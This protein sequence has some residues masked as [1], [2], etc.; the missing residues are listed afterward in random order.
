MACAM[1]LLPVISTFSAAVAEQ[2][3]LSAGSRNQA[4]RSSYA[5]ATHPSDSYFSLNRVLEID[6]EM[7]PADWEQ[8]RRQT[9]TLFDILSG[10]CLASPQA[11]VFSWFRASVSVD[12][13]TYGE[14]GVRKK[15]FLGSL[16][17][18][19]PALKL[20]FDKFIDDQLLGGVMQRLTLNN[21]KQDASMIN[22]CLASGV[23]AAAGLPTPRCNFATVSVNGEKLGL[24]VHVESVKNAFLAGHFADPG[25]N[26]YEGTVSDFR[27][28][29]RGTFVKK[30][31]RTAAEW[32]D[33][34]AVVEALQDPSAAGLEKLEAAVDLESFLTFWATEVLVG[35]WD[36]YAGN[37]NNFYLYREPGAPF[38]FIPWGLDQVFSSIDGPFD[39]FRSPPSVTAHG[40]IAHRLY[41][42]AA[43]RQ[44]Y[45]ARLVE[46]LDT[47]WN[48]EQLLRQ[49]DEMADLVQIHALAARRGKARSDT[50]RV[51]RFI[52]QRRA[53]ILAAIDPLPPSWPWP[54]T[55]ADICWPQV[56][57]FD[58]A[59]ATTWGSKDN[60]AAS[61]DGR[62]TF[63]NYQLG[64]DQQGLKN[65]WATAG[66]EDEDGR[67]ESE[68]TPRAS[69][70][71]LGFRPS[72]DLD[73]LTILLP[74]E[75]V[76]S[77]SSVVF[78]S[79]GVEG[80]RLVLPP[81][82]SAVKTFEMVGRGG[83][84]FVEVSTEPGAK[85]SGRFYG[86]IFSF[87]NKAEPFVP[88]YEPGQV[89]EIVVDIGL[90]I[91]EVAARGEPLDWFE[92]Y[93]ATDVP[94]ELGDF[95]FADD[96][97]SES[98][99][100]PF[101]AAAR[102]E[103]GAYLQIQL[104]KGGWP[105]FALGRGEA[106]GIWTVEGQLVA[107]IDWEAGQADE[108]TSFARVPDIKGEFQTVGNPTPG[109]PNSIQTLVAE[110]AGRAPATFRLRGNWPNPFNASTAIAFDLPRPMPVSLVVHDVLGRPVR[111]LHRGQILAA[112][113]QH[114]TWDGR[115]G[116]G[117]TMATGIYLYELRAGD[118]FTAV[119]RMALIR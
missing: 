20:R 82:Y 13:E 38:V 34:D 70:S 1:A 24:Y 53:A 119:G 11:D 44:A 17:T 18:V 110:E 77:G 33:I 72:G 57:I 100:V 81:P 7:A 42:G 65:P 116:H 47:V 2:T 40:A 46:L 61:K 107:R 113:L 43:T 101:P 114:T 75:R 37:R 9:R 79:A 98:K 16:S 76:K 22:T 109:A 45:V 84:D 118:N 6:I 86:S 95:L 60:E 35:H 90:L 36:G 58:L 14:V 4:H 102:L 112:G 30:T 19:K 99:R 91:N 54:L 31:N 83:I 10:D 56:G 28:Q 69:I 68:N 64:R 63:A 59:F 29:W 108:G 55:P 92:L 96:L 39:N 67:R 105:G 51:R 106:L 115:D 97:D 111:T 41:R 25:G 3:S 21:S 93:N 49:V 8:L 62:V 12:G 66:I 15:G 73:I 52:R 27:P 48:E 89:E 94:I 78:G 87:D 50:E 88:A 5:D 103:P 26:L 117:R 104:D 71:A 74:L 80:F 23:F 85:V 32:S